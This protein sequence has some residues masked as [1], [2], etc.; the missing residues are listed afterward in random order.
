MQELSETGYDSIFS[1][2][3]QIS[4]ADTYFR[5]LYIKHAVNATSERRNIH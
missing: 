2:C 5:V 3:N 1:P 4:R